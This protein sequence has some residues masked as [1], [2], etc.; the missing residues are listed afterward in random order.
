MNWTSSV[1]VIV[2]MVGLC[3][4]AWS[5]DVTIWPEQQ[6]RAVKLHLHYGD[7]GDYQ[8]ID[9]VRLV[10]LVVVDTKGVRISFLR[11]VA[12]TSDD[13]TLST[14]SLRLGDW[15][16]GTYLASARY[17]NGFYI[18]DS[19]NRAIATTREWFPDP[20]DSA[21]YQKFSKALFHVGAS[22][23][24]FDRR[25]GHRLE[26]IPLAD[27]FAAADGS[28]LEVQVLFDGAA[29]KDHVVELGDEAAASKGAELRSDSRGIVRVK[30]DR[31]GFY[32][33][34]VDHR[35]P[36]KYPEL[37]SFDDYTASLVFSR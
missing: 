4:N 2:G 5:H 27:P 25:V 28:T 23:A 10:D 31:A 7:P 15:P 6:G 3:G 33:F 18:H 36:S 17:D 1:A 32:R 20:I 14:P 16:A 22:G 26:F 8:P 37:Y 11:D 34:A 19:E 12:R 24:G 35:A 29:L 13:R 30:L 9:K 21:H